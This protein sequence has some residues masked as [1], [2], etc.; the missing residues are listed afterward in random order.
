MKQFEKD[1]GIA[2]EIRVAGQIIEKGR[3]IDEQLER[4]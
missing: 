4:M 3:K 1:R 2:R